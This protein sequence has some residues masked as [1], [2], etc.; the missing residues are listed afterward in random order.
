MK[1]HETGFFSE[2]EAVSDDETMLIFSFSF[3]VI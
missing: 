1:Q 3:L 2:V